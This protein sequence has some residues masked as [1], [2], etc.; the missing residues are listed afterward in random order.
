MRTWKSY[1]LAVSTATLES[2][3]GTSHIAVTGTAK[4]CLA[5]IPVNFTLNMPVRFEATAQKSLTLVVDKPTTDLPAPID[6]IVSAKIYKRAQIYAGNIHVN[7]PALIP[8]EVF[9]FNPQLGDVAVSYNGDVLSARVSLTGQI[10]SAA[11]TKAIN[12]RLQA[13]SGLHF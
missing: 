3:F 13:E 11:A 6:S 12:D 8:K 2:G 9:L 7:L 10:S 5:P 1:E 4:L